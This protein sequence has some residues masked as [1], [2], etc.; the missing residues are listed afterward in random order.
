[1]K[2]YAL[3]V[4]VKFGENCFYP[5][6]GDSDL[7][8]DWNI[9]LPGIKIKPNKDAAKQQAILTAARPWRGDEGAKLMEVTSYAN[10]DGRRVVGWDDET[11]QTFWRIRLN[12]EFGYIIWME[13]DVVKN[14]VFQK[15][16]SEHP[17]FLQAKLTYSKIP[18]LMFPSG[19]WFGGVDNDGNGLGGVAPQQM[20]VYINRAWVKKS[21]LNLQ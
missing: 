12:E 13:G 21:K 18:W 9:K 4:G 1:L 17:P 14:R 2:K 7:I 11:D 5:S 3:V 10:I 19:M 15:R 8:H 16:I 6:Q 20:D